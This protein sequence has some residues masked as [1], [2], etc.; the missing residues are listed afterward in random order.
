MN[1]PQVQENVISQHDVFAIRESALSWCLYAVLM[2]I[3][4]FATFGN[5]STHLF[6]THDQEYLQDTA[7]SQ[8]DFWFVVSPQRIYPGRPTFNLYLWAAYKLFK[9]EPAGYHLLQVWLH[10]LASL[11]V[12]FTFRR[13]GAT[14]ELS[15]IGGL[16]FL[17]NVAHFRAVHWISATSYIL[18]L[19]FGL[20]AVLLYHR[21]LEA[22]RRVWTLAAALV[23]AAA[24]CAHPSAA[25]V[26]LLCLFLALQRRLAIWRAAYACL[27]LFA[28]AFI[29]GVV[30]TV[31]YSGAPQVEAT[32]RAPE[33]LAVIRN[34]LWMGG[35][36]ITN[37]FWLPDFILLEEYTYWELAAGFLLL[38]GS[39]F[40]AVRKGSSLL[41]WTVWSVAFILP[42]ITSQILG[43]ASGPSRYLYLS[44]AGTCFI[45]AWAIQT[46]TIRAKRRSKNASR[47][48]LAGIVSI[49]LVSSFLG[50]GKTEAISLYHSGRTYFARGDRQLALR[51][52]K[53]AITQA[54][55]VLPPDV[56]MR[57]AHTAFSLGKSVEPTLQSAL[58]GDP[59][60]R[61]LNMLLGVN[62]FL[63]SDSKVRQSGEKRVQT[64]L[65]SSKGNK[66]LRWH[67][68]VA[69]NN[70]AGFHLEAE[71]Y[72]KAI[73]LSYNALL[74]SPNY[75]MAYLNLGHALHR[76]GEPDKAVKIFQVLLEVQPD[77]WKA[78]LGLALSYQSLDKIKKAI[79]AYRR[80]LY[81][82]PNL[83][84]VHFDLGAHY[85][86]R[87]E[88]G[89]AAEYFRQTLRLSPDFLPARLALA[90]SYA[91]IGQY[92]L[93]IEEY[94]NTL[95]LHP[96]ND[97][98]RSRLKSLLE[99]E[100][101]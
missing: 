15:L 52:F 58:A 69:F 95:S 57:L 31:V 53:K 68:A 7:A 80:V 4:T 94:R 85:F 6:H 11:L 74:Y 98:A 61:E 13:L 56:Y 10:F 43:N 14:F 55:A 46:L 1:L 83:A 78:I 89:E 79:I 35:R 66:V 9:E 23:L 71:D 16:L 48:L 62:A 28:A 32:L 25:I 8:G 29:S 20:G 60:S 87:G 5:L 96:G 12:A 67:T 36:L 54:P 84:E 33:F 92:H 86:N 37:A 27:P 91:R 93:A 17:M 81:L 40:L 99:R 76:K 72:Q 45:F 39:L 73:D 44:S 64:T 70:L 34:L 38:S 3:L 88:F 18:A 51:Q 30:L 26:A 63:S 42:F 2:C 77:N 19:V 100:Q 22:D 50:L 97:E 47:V 24:V 82:N 59:T 65:E 21:G 49:I 101:P 75:A 41:F 90:R